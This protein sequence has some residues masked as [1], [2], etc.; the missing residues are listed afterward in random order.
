MRKRLA[1]AEIKHF[2]RPFTAPLYKLVGS[3][4]CPALRQAYATLVVSLL[5]TGLSGCGSAEA[6]LVAGYRPEEPLD[7]VM[8]QSPADGGASEEP[9]ATADLSSLLAIDIDPA[10]GPAPLSVLMTARMLNE[11]P[12]PSDSTFTWDFGDGSVGSGERVSH[13]YSQAGVYLV[14]LTLG[15]ACRSGDLGCRETDSGPVKEATKQAVVHVAAVADTGPAP[16]GPGELILTPGVGTVWAGDRGG[17]FS[18]GAAT[19]TL[20]NAGADPINW[21]VS[22]PAPWLSLSKTGGTLA[23]GASEPLAVRP[24]DANAAAMAVGTYTSTLTFRNLTTGVGTADRTYT[25]VINAPP[26]QLAVTPSSPGSYSITQGNPDEWFDVGPVEPVAQG[27][28]SYLLSNTGQSPLDW[29]AI[30]DQPWLAAN[31]ASGQLA[32]GQSL[33]VAVELTA[34]VGAVEAG[35]HLANV[36]FVNQT[37]ITGST[38]RQVSLTVNPPPGQLAVS[39]ETPYAASGAAGGPFSPASLVYTL[40]NTGGQPA[41]WTAAKTQSWLDVCPSSGTLAAGGSIAVG[42]TINASADSLAV[43]SYNDTVTFMNSTNGNGNTTRVV[44]LVVSGAP[45]GA[46]STSPAASLSATGGQGGAFTPAGQ[47][48]TLTNTGGQAINWSA[49]N[50]QSWVTLL[51]SSG[52]LSPGASAMVTVSINA[53]ANN[54]GAGNYNDT[55]TFT[56]TT[57]GNGN[58]TRGVSLSV[59]PPSIDAP[60][61][62]FTA[63]VTSGQV[64]LTV[65]FDAS[66][67]TTPSH[68]A[69]F[70]WD[71]ADDNSAYPATYGAGPG[72]NINTR[73][74]YGK[75]VAHRFA[76]AGTYNV[77]MTATTETGAQATAVVIVTATTSTGT[78]YYVK[79]GGN[80][81][82]DGLSDATAWATMAKANTAVSIGTVH[83]GDT[84]LFRRGDVFQGCIKLNSGCQGTRAYPITFGAYG[85]GNRPELQQF[86]DSDS[87]IFF[88]EDPPMGS[89]VVLE[90]LYVRRTAWTTTPAIF[91]FYWVTPAYPN[92]TIRNCVIGGGTMGSIAVTV[93]RW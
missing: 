80:D 67:T 65:V 8:G 41:N 27:L 31:P 56:N 11:E 50:S 64:P 15:L 75:L 57:N 51:G 88:F 87:G 63:S 37:T 44:S 79:N 46:L 25:L 69:D 45:P 42:V 36:A 53:N 9:D 66:S 30:S 1:D 85:T 72:S 62:A 32:V 10:E 59:S 16:D 61:A 3:I 47:T 77:A 33:T 29:T 92:I 5:V 49:S 14:T 58:G 52:T 34:Q 43:A 70:V 83:A 71:F 78:T 4:R 86:V 74:D 13:V 93:I 35:L 90:D 26:G 73:H 6:P 22:E 23:P 48:Y 17:P 68:I 76:N 24:V 60:V 28:I 82:A 20:A 12:F 18:P 2:P 39:P 19:F 55:V 89:G 91:S 21:S 40:S 84:I 81:S 54:L 7:S 38:A